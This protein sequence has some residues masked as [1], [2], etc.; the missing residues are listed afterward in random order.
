MKVELK[1]SEV[2]L[3]INCLETPNPKYDL[4]AA[5]HQLLKKMKQVKAAI[6]AQE[7]RRYLSMDDE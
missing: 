7:G 4:T 3:I 1:T 2:S 6:D 5:G